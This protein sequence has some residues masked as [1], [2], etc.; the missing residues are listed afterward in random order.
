MLDTSSRPDAFAYS[1]L[2][3]TIY[4]ESDPTY[5]TNGTAYYQGSTIAVEAD[6]DPR[7]FEGSIGLTVAWG[8][9]VSDATVSSVIWDLRE[10]DT[11]DFYY[12]NNAEVDEIV[13][14]GIRLNRGNGTGTGFE[15]RSPFARIEF[16]N[17]ARSDTRLSGSRAF[18]GKFVGRTVD[19][20]T[21]VI[22]TWS[23]GGSSYSSL[24]EGAYAAELDP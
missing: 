22:G 7:F 4:Y 18:S 15:S 9:R 10:V 2:E 3:Q 13:F 6:S 1:P 17:A 14:S 5:P 19:G 16:V 21:G 8:S 12:Y 24:L 11:G 20:P 23:L